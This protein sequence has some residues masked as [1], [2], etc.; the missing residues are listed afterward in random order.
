MG[1][2]QL[3]GWYS[4]SGRIYLELILEEVLLV[5]KLAIKAKQLLLFLVEGL[6]KSVSAPVIDLSGTRHPVR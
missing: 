4:G 1:Y 3:V 5:G 6:F 2:V